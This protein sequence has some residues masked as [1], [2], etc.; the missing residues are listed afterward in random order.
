MYTKKWGQ[1]RPGKR[2]KNRFPGACCIV[3]SIALRSESPVRGPRHCGPVPQSPSSANEATVNEPAADG[4]CGGSPRGCYPG[5][6]AGRAAA[7][8]MWRREVRV[9]GGGS[10]RGGCIVG[11]ASARAHAWGRGRQGRRGSLNVTNSRTPFATLG[12]ATTTTTATRRRR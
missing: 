3:G 5:C 11:S 10:T 8:E 2:S 4:W 6:V 12:A 1:F 9:G 7:F